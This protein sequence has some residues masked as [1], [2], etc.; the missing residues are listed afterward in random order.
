MH[1]SAQPKL[2]G[3]HQATLSLVL[4]SKLEKMEKQDTLLPDKEPYS[5]IAKQDDCIL[6]PK[7]D[8]FKLKKDQGKA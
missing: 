5:P 1:I 8:S 6:N 2:C 3:P 7:M 4:Q